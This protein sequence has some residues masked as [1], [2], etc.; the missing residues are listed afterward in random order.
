MNRRTLLLYLMLLL[1]V[2][3][4]LFALFFGPA[5]AFS[6]RLAND[7]DLLLF[8]AQES[9]PDFIGTY[10]LIHI[11][12]PDAEI[13]DEDLALIDRLGIPLSLVLSADGTAKLQIFD[14]NEDLVWDGTAMSLFSSDTVAAFSFADGILTVTE[15]GSLMQF[16]KERFPAS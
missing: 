10:R 4:A 9:V 8:S 12:S 15:N 13:S 7:M 1:A 5:P 16:Q 6:P 3:L 2:L 14:L 11:E